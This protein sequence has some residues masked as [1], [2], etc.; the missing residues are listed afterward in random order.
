MTW[1]YIDSNLEITR[2]FPLIEFLAIDAA[3]TRKMVAP[4]LPLADSLG[5]ERDATNW[6]LY[7][8]GLQSIAFLWSPQMWLCD[9]SVSGFPDYAS[10][11]N[12]A[13]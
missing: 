4:L 2:V 9:E 11:T 6:T 10:G 12:T 7:L 1:G 3:F 13:T 8:S 5:R